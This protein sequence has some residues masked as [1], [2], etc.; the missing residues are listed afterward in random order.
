MQES[1]S[2]A[3][4]TAEDALNAT[5]VL[6]EITN[7]VNE[8]FELNTTIASASEQQS[9]ISTNIS[10][11]ISDINTTAKE[12]AVQSNEASQSSTQINTISLELRSLIASYKL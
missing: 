6:D 8:I 3:S 5:Q 4:S 10:N 11:G 2:S 1:S 7:T 9:V 12:A